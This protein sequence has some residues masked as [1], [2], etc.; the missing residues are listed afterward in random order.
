VK[1]VVEI[2]ERAEHLEKLRRKVEGE[3]FLRKQER[4]QEQKKREQAL[5][6]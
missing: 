1:S 4:Y 2:L 5:K 3:Q 6:Y